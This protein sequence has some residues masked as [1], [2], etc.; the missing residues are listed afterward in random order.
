MKQHCKRL[1]ILLVVV[2]F[3]MSA[4][5]TIF[6][7][8]SAEATQDRITISVASYF[9]STHP[10]IVAFQEVFKPMVEE[11]SGGRITVNIYPDNQLGGEREFT[12]QLRNGDIQMAING[13][14]LANTLPRLMTP[15]LPFLWEDTEHAMSTLNSPIGDEILE[16]IE[17]LDILPVAWSAN[18]WRI[19]STQGK[20]IRSLADA[21]GI[22]LRI[23]EVE[24]FILTF[25]A[26]GFNAVTMSFAELF[27]AMQQGVVDGQ[28]NPAPT[29]VASNFYEVQDHLAITHHMFEPNYY[30][31]NKPWFESL[32]LEDQ[33]LIREAA[34][35]TAEYEVELLMQEDAAALE[36]AE[37]QGVTITYPD[38]DEF[39][40]A[41]QPV[42]ETYG[43]RYDWFD[44]LIERIR[45]NAP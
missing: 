45:A 40:A 14:L 39:L 12:E 24:Y 15:S 8:G 6:A 1:F 30:A 25:E 10:Q 3:S 21:R 29:F 11:Q 44:D 41:V 16:G 7:G 42:Y 36:Y 33:Q 23:P 38:R 22:T 17:E 31:V 28:D 34:E 27:G 4:T 2:T 43:N 5:S 37:E 9:A 35:Q 18:G 13:M 20:P 26:L 32:S 19:I